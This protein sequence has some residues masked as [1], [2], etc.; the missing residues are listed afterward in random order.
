MMYREYLCTKSGA[1][2]QHFFCF[3]NLFSLFLLIIIEKR[4]KVATNS[5]LY[6]SLK[7]P[8]RL[9]LKK[10][11]SNVDPYGIEPQ[12][13]EPESFILSIKLW[14]QRFDRTS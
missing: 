1:K 10:F 9:F 14:V 5:H 3:C 4:D 6:L 12:S 13:K 8:K 7:A 11:S 2:V